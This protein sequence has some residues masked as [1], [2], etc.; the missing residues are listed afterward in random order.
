MPPIPIYLPPQGHS[1][2]LYFCVFSSL[3][4]QWEIR[5]PLSLMYFLILSVPLCVTT[6]S[7]HH[8]LR[9]LHKCFPCLPQLPGPA[10]A[11]APCSGP[12]LCLPHSLWETTGP[13]LLPPLRVHVFLAWS[14]QIGFILNFSVKEGKKKNL[15]CLGYSSQTTVVICWFTMRNCKY[16]ASTMFSKLW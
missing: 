1:G 4:Q 8:C 7:S 9:F 3:F 2:F 6:I 12:L 16:Q 10:Q 5:C 14:H 11:P 15:V 13:W